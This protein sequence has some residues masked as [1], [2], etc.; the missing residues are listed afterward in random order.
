MALLPQWLADDAWLYLESPAAA[1]VTPGAG[2]FLHREGSTR[3]SRHALYRRAIP[4]A[5]TLA[6]D[7]NAHGAAT[8]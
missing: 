5:A 1:D 7:S 2:W 3:E 8:E 6:A 4:A